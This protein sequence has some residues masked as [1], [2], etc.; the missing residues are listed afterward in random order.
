MSRR[1]TNVCFF[2]DGS[3]GRFHLICR[4][5]QSRYESLHWTLIFYTF[6]YIGDT[7]P[8]SFHCGCWTWEL[9]KH[10]HVIQVSSL[11]RPAEWLRNCLRSSVTHTLS[12]WIYNVICGLAKRSLSLNCEDVALIV[13]S[14]PSTLVIL[15][16]ITANPQGHALFWMLY[17]CYLEF[18]VSQAWFIP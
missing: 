11:V 15:A 2:V 16:C 13:A 7:K 1:K 10:R 8:L 6:A 5:K 3:N 12:T 17:F 18:L 4:S 9:F 14:W